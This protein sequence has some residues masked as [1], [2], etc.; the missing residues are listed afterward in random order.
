MKKIHLLFAISII[1]I[2]LVGLSNVSAVDSS[3][4]KTITVDDTDFKIPPEYENGDLSNISYIKDKWRYFE[5]FS[6]KHDSHQEF[7]DFGY[8]LTSNN[9]HN[10]QV[11]KSGNHDMIIMS[12]YYEED[13]IQIWFMCGNAT[14]RINQN[15]SNISE[16]VREIIKTSPKQNLTS[17]EFYS[18]FYTYQIRY[19]KYLDD[20]EWVNNDIQQF[21]NS[22]KLQQQE[23]SE[24]MWWYMF[25]YY[26][27]NY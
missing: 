15:G 5:I 7:H 14:Y 12:R 18:K 10:I 26:S 4:W 17:Q 13:Y 22:K 27:N 8:E 1:V 24:N 16:N 23:Q 6:Y 25:G 11:D 19:M 9:L 21:E 2:L 3:K 20:L